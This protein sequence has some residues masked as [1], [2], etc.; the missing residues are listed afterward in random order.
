MDLKEQLEIARKLALT[1]HTGQMD[2][3]GR[4]IIEHI[5]AVVTGVTSIEE[6]TV[7]Y[8]HEVLED[9]HLTPNHL[10]E[11]GFNDKIVWSVICIS[12]VKGESYSEYIQRVK[13]NKIA[14]EVKKIDLLHNMKLERLPKITKK[15]I[16][17]NKKY[18]KALGTLIEEE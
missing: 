10:Y 11:I 18:L 8:L 1:L 3:A 5:I 17:R 7:A 9:T 15:D 14:R 12:R 4:P 16:D 6:K 13:N 2:K